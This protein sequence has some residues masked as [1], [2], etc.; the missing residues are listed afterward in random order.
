MNHVKRFHEDILEIMA[1]SERHA[2][3]TLNIFFHAKSRAIY[4]WIH[5]IVAKSLPFD[6]VEDEDYRTICKLERISVETTQKYM[7][8]IGAEI[9]KKIKARLKDCTR[10]GLML[11]GWDAGGGTHYCGLGRG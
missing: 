1:E 4:G 3:S 7:Y 11:D 2:R 10:L 8:L 5:F 9:L 6:S